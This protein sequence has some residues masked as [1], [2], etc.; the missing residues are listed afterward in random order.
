MQGDLFEILDCIEYFREYHMNMSFIPVCWYQVVNSDS[1]LLECV[2][3][4]L[5][6]SNCLLDLAVH[7]RQLWHQLKDLIQLVAGNGNDAFKRIAEDDIALRILSEYCRYIQT[8]QIPPAKLAL[9]QQ[10]LAH[11]EPPAS[12]RHW[13]Q[14]SMWQGPKPARTFEVS[15]QRLAREVSCGPEVWSHKSPPSPSRGH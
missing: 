13:S 14:R 12:P 15:S 8:E 9:P 5:T 1:K 10:R 11:S 2:S 4:S 3:H 6:L 7:S